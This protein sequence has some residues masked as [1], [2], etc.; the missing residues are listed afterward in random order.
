MWI[1]ASLVGLL[2][3][4]LVIAAIVLLTTTDDQ[5]ADEVT[6]ES[7]NLEDFLNYR[8]N[9]KT[10]NG[11]WVSGKIFHSMLNFGKKRFVN[12]LQHLQL[13]ANRRSVVIV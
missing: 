5:H 9:P 11:T 4:A 8:Y 1:I 7:L 10:F 2:V 13:H 6:A 3:V 12:D